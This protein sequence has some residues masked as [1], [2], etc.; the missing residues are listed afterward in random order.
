MKQRARGQLGLSMAVGGVV[1]LKL[2]LA[3]CTAEPRTSMPVVAID[4]G[5]PSE[6][7]QGASGPGGATEI[8]V[9]WAVAQKL[10]ALLKRRG[11]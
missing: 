6:T 2:L 5:H 8:Q 9:N 10:Q 4:P 7:S 3:A 1:I 11:Y